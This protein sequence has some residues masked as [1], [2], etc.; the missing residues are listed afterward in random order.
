MLMHKCFKVTVGQKTSKSKTIK[1]S[2]PQD[3][4]LAPLLFSLHINYTYKIS[5]IKLCEHDHCYS[6][7]VPRR[8]R[9]LLD[10]RF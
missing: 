7:Q 4:L 2:L 6:E 5:K 8:L 9:G 3:L 1:I 10:F